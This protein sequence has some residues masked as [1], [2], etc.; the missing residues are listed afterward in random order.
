M[1]FKIES[2]IETTLL[3]S[4]DC[5]QT[6]SNCIA[7]FELAPASSTKEELT[8]KGKLIKKQ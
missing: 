5:S 4:N 1:Q 7:P 3:D 6:S 8:K 2:K